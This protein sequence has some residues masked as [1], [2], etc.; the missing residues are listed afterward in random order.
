MRLRKVGGAAATAAA[1]AMAILPAG[2]SA[3]KHPGPGGQHNVSINVSENPIVAG[4]QLAIFGR[5]TGPNHG[6][7]QVVLWHRINPRPRF[8]RVQTTTTDANGFYVFFRQ[9]GVVNTNRHWYVK[10]LGA[11]SRTIH[12]K[13]FSI[14]TLSGPADGSN[15]LTGPAHRVTFAG[16]VSPFV[17]GTRVLLQR[18]NSAIAGNQWTTI[19]Q[20]RV[21]PGGTF[22]ITHTFRVPGDANIRAV[23]Q[24][25]RRNIK[26][27]SNVLSYEISQA[28]NPALTINASANPIDVGQSVTLTGA[29]QNGPNQ[30]VT[31]MAKTRGGAFQQ[32]AQTATDGSGNYTFTQTPINNTI[33][34]VTGGGRQSAQLFEGVKDILTANVSSTNVN[35]GDQ[36]TFSGTVSPN[37]TGHVIYLQRQNASGNGF[38]TVQVAFVG[39][40]STYSIQRRLFAPGTKVFRV[41]IPGGPFNQGDASQPFTITVNPASAQQ[42]NNSQ[43]TPTSEG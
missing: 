20:G 9:P 35:A 41:F 43:P 42:V 26:S 30:Q 19:D 5:L 33:Y 8:T 18:D 13:V 38:H 11:R 28:Q 6:N 31:L 4:D 17:V 36:V 16:T 32:V 15:L 10:S 1:C 2:A 23:V 12:E 29:L 14:V 27:N 21:K 40:G 37:K 7:R 34:Q 39:A 22:S 3:S 24:P 25:T